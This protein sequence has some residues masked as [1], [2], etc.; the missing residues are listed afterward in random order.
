VMMAGLLFGPWVGLFAGGI[1][2]MLGDVIT[3][4][5][6]YAPLTLVVKGLEGFLAGLV[7]NPRNCQNRLGWRD[8]AG[9]I[10]GGLEMVSGYFLGEFFIIGVGFASLGEVPG[11]FIQIGV[12]ALIALAVAASVRK[13]ALETYP[14]LQTT[15]FARE[16][17]LEHENEPTLAAPQEDDGTKDEFIAQ[18]DEE[19]K[20]WGN[21]AT[22]KDGKV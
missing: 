19:F 4:Y 20:N 9:V 1:G 22:T 2:S 6:Q 16:M 21:E 8:F 7:S 17:P 13:G 11:N 3:G 14:Q 10:F 18:L 5:F 15:F 12:G